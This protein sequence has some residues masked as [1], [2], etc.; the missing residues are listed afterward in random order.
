M[1]RP[2][3]TMKD[4]LSFVTMETGSK[5]LNVGCLKDVIIVLC[6]VGIRLTNLTVWIYMNLK[7]RILP[8]LKQFFEKKKKC[9]CIRV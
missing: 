2:V 8:Q 1:P 7:I 6:L 4:K 3:S 5:S 9:Q